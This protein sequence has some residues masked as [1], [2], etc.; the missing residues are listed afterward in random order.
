MKQLGMILVV[1]AAIAGFIALFEIQAN[2]HQPADHQSISP[3]ARRR[4]RLSG[5]LRFVFP[6]LRD[7]GCERKK[8]ARQDDARMRRLR[9]VLSAGQAVRTPDPFSATACDGCAKTPTIVRRSAKR[10][11]TTDTWWTVPSRA[12]TVP[13]PAAP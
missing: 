9:G 10:L 3:S 5:V 12:E 6:S 13:N 4:A 11:R 7:S 2:A 8:G 1:V